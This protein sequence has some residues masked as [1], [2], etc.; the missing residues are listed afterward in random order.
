MYDSSDH[1]N[2]E[3]RYRDLHTIRVMAGLT[4]SLLLLVAAVNLWPLPGDDAPAD[5]IYTT[6]GPE[7]IQMEEIV[8]TNQRRQ[9]P[10]PPAPLPPIIVPNDQ[11]IEE[12]PL[13]FT[14]AF[15][16]IEEPGIDKDFSPGLPEDA[17]TT[18][19]V[20]TDPKPVRVALPEYTK[21][22]KKK[23]IRAEIVFEMLI[24]KKGRVQESKIVERFL[25]GKDEDDPKQR[26][27]KLGYGIEE[28]L[29]AAAAR[30]LFRPARKNGVAVSSYHR[31]TLSIGK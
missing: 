12:E 14:D 18:A 29:H 27:D 10:P 16:P 4:A 17:T 7:T 22:A 23:K 31:V 5:M 21:E 15:L 13:D 11:I 8:Q 26:V 28:A 24:D 30:W 9:A 2:R 1:H 19:R 25:L 6:R 20:D 3:Q